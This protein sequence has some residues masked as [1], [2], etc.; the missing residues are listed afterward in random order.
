MLTRLLR[1]FLQ[2]G[3]SD[4]E[5][6]VCLFICLSKCRTYCLSVWLCGLSIFSLLGGSLDPSLQLSIVPKTVEQSGEKYFYVCLTTVTRALSLCHF[7]PEPAKTLDCSMELW[8]EAKLE[9]LPASVGCWYKF[10]PICS[11]S[12]QFLDS[13]AHQRVLKSKGGGA[14]DFS[15]NTPP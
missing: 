5:R 4:N 11:H 2:K 1:N 7:P 9:L 8:I 12:F 3:K 13:P 6:F 10:R 14:S 15:A